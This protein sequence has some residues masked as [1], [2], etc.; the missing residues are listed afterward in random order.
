[1]KTHHLRTHRSDE[2][3]SREGQLAWQLAATAI[4]PVDVDD[5]VVDMVVNRVIDNAAVAAA[6]LARKPVVSA[7]SQALSHPVSIGGDGATV[8]GADAA[9]R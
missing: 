6:A 8:F 5:E 7:R 3:L 2:N 9:R 4:D 1:M